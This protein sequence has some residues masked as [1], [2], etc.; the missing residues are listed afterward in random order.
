MST[1]TPGR[2]ESKRAWRFADA[3]PRK[4]V[5][6]VW[7]VVATIAGGYYVVVKGENRS[8]FNRWQPVLADLVAGE[9]VYYQSAF[10]TPPI[11]GLILYPF[12]L[13]PDPWAMAA[14]FA[15]KTA[16][17]SLAMW[18]LLTEMPLERP[19]RLTAGLLVL[20]VASRPLLG[21]LLHGNVNLWI[22]F[23]IVAALV[24]F[25]RRRDVA[26]GLCLSLAVA[27]KV[28]PALLI[29]YFVVKRAWLVCAAAVLGLALWLVVVPGSILGFSH[30]RMLLEH[31]S[32]M[33]LR[34]Y[35]V[36]GAVDTEQVN[37]SLPALLYR[38]GTDSV[39]IKAE[40]GRPDVSVNFLTMTQE[41]MRW[42]SRALIGCLLAALVW[43]VRSPLP[44]RKDFALWQEA[45][46]VLMAMLLVSERSW[47]HHYVTILPS[48]A[49]LVSFAWLHGVNAWSR[50]AA[51]AAVVGVAV[52]MAL[53]SNDLARPLF[54]VHGA[55]LAQ[56]YGAYVWGALCLFAAHWWTLRQLRN[57]AAAAVRTTIAN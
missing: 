41:Q 33:M 34:P 8:A 49:A 27:C 45:G 56:A 16:A 15:F 3:D 29:V 48:V 9:D 38:L 31:W 28:T 26:A 25:R 53:T 4:V 47:K 22:L 12:S 6:A 2:D 43:S 17:T 37:Q 40:R 1:E 39:A 10:P 5:I 36:E 7:L 20:G 32:H 55:K 52:A 11:M 18:W 42:I 30:N 46:L 51:A 44:D 57:H 14:W 24:A 35:V 50:K 13:L 21:D 19:F 54:G 23:L